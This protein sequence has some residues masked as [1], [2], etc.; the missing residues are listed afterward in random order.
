MG[1]RTFVAVHS[2]D[3]RY[4]CYRFQWGGDGESLE[5]DWAGFDAAEDR[6]PTATGLTVEGVLARL[7]PLS[8]ETLFV[9]GGEKRTYLVVS[10]ALVTSASPVK[11]APDA[12]LVSVEHADGA[13][14]IRR[15]ARTLKGV[16][17]DAVDAGLVPRV[18]ARGYLAVRLARHPDAT[19]RP[20]F[21]SGARHRERGPPPGTGDS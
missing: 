1:H 16:L 17:G 3:G 13:A 11:R 2:G 19:E 5:R 9:R 21:V 18:V 6:S 14:S 7:D 15:F 12:V 8:D 10:L 4:D 20:L